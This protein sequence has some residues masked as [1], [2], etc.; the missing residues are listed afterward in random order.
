MQALQ[1]ASTGQPPFDFD[2]WSQIPA[3]I[4]QLLLG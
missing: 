4:A 3:L 1:F 2:D